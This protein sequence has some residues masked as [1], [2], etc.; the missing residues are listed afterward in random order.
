MCSDELLDLRLLADAIAQIVELRSAN[1]AA[2]HSVDGDDRGRMHGKNLLT[3]NAVGDAAH[4]D[5]LVDAAVLLGDDG[6]LERLV[7]LA[8]AFLDAVQASCTARSEF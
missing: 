8:V 4:G 7:A 2:A 5:G 6:T 1:L 3:A